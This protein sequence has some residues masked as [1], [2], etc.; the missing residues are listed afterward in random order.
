[1]K[2]NDGYDSKICT[3][4]EITILLRYFDH[5]DKEPVEDKLHKVELTYTEF[6]RQR[7]RWREAFLLNKNLG[8]HYSIYH[9]FT[10]CLLT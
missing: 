10:A 5:R 2:T 8:G 6:Y 1:M 9:S 4:S 3:L 7:P